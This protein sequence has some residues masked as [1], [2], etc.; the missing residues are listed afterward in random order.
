MN[1]ASP[2]R[3]ESLPPD[4]AAVINAACDRFEVAWRDGGRP[5]IEAFLLPSLSDAD[6]AVLRRE[7]INLDVYYR[8]RAG[9]TPQAE[10]YLVQF[11]CLDRQWLCQ[12]VSA[13][14]SSEQ[15]STPEPPS[16]A[17]VRKPRPA[18]EP[19]ALVGRTLGR[20]EIREELDHGGMG[21][22]Y[23]ALDTMLHREV[24]LKVMWPHIA[25]GAQARARFLR[26]A[27]TA[28]AVESDHIV[29]IYDVNETPEGWLYLTMPLLH[30]ETLECRLRR[31]GR[32]SL[33]DLLRVGQEV[34]AGL[35]AAHARGLIHRDIKPKNI[36]LE[37]AEAPGQPAGSPD[38]VTKVTA[39]KRPKILDFGLARAAG[40]ADLTQPGAI[41][42]TPAY[43]A[44]E[45]ARGDDELDARSDLFSLGCVL[46]RA[47]AGQPPFDGK[48][49]SAILHAVEHSEPAPLRSLRPEL[50]ESLDALIRRLLAKDRASRPKS[51]VE[52]GRELADVSFGLHP[53]PLMVDRPFPLEA[54]AP[55]QVPWHMK[56]LRRRRRIVASVGVALMLRLG[57][58]LA[59]HLRR[60][61][62]IVASVGV[63]L[64]VGLGVALV[65]HLWPRSEQTLNAQRSG[66]GT[67][68]NVPVTI[69]NGLTVAKNGTG[70]FTTIQDALAKVKPGMT[71]QVLDD[72][73][74]PEALAIEGPERHAGI[75][76]EA[77]RGATLEFLPHFVTALSI[78]NAP[79]VTV[80]GFRFKSA[81]KEDMFNALVTVTGCCSGLRLEQLE[82]D[83]TGICGLWL[84][85][86]SEHPAQPIIV[87]NCV[88]NLAL[89][90]GIDVFGDEAGAGHRSGRI[91]IRDNKL[92]GGVRGLVII[93]GIADV[94]LTGNVL[95]GWL[96]AGIQVE[97][98]FPSLSGIL[99]A[100]NT[101]IHS[102]SGFRLWDHRPVKPL[103]D[104]QVTLANNLLLDNKAGDLYWTSQKDA[105]GRE[106][107]LEPGNVEMLIETWRFSNNWR[108]RQGVVQPWQIKLA[109]ADKGVAGPEIQALAAQR[110]PRKDSPLATG[111][112]GGDLP[113]YV[114]A[115]PPEGVTPWDWDRTWKARVRP[116]KD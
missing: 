85:G 74:Y 46:Y 84:K 71:I 31:E 27:R 8:Q 16:A 105:A 19:L 72:A 25:A 79:G 3:F 95:Q 15:G 4:I 90:D 23:R 22:V 38:S 50:P 87:R 35:A 39:F 43:M 106:I 28:A 100:N 78:N 101:V 112:A 88:I 77:S 24:A 83:A 32:L 41:S 13:T 34:C 37:A 92:N 29:S 98:P 30:G 109:P 89:A 66:S 21:V 69:V 91:A 58:A 1:E 51:A 93:G 42:G 80:R 63:A 56:V 52:V 48:S 14:Q 75:V 45:Q 17:S 57:V 96:Q 59:A 116:G 53:A 49:S 40:A 26:E 62:R 111:G 73:T 102:G 81:S 5:P 10:E 60:R 64:I 11:P 113:T 12:A 67:K 99:I 9:E 54:P 82:M 76:L 70:Q 86:W 61:P 104:G 44:P 94:H 6:N 2:H 36:W 33:P 107:D 97:D 65:A 110:R 68:V 55:A 7:L 108:Q 115:L 114:G 20:Y 18:T 103:R 47:A